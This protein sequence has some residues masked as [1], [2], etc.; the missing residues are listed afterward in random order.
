MAQQESGARRARSTRICSAV[1]KAQKPSNL[2]PCLAFFPFAPLS[3]CP[4][5]I[6]VFLLS[7]SLPAFHFSFQSC[8]FM[9]NCTCPLLLSA[10][11]P[12]PSCAS[13]AVT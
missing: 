10:V 5:G 2:L 3:L 6:P 4:C 7:S 11:R 1:T 12:A 9:T 13:L 8:T